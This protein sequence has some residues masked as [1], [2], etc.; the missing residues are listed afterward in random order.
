MCI[1]SFLAKNDRSQQLMK[2]TAHR[3]LS[4]GKAIWI[5][6]KKKKNGERSYLTSALTVIFPLS[7]VQ[8][9]LSSDRKWKKHFM[10]KPIRS[11]Y[12][13]HNWF[14]THS[15]LDFPLRYHR[16][17]R[18][19]SKSTFQLQIKCGARHCPAIIVDSSQM[20]HITV[21][22]CARSESHTHICWYVHA[23]RF[24]EV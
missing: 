4:L 10:A 20:M 8:L 1:F 23:Q 18:H 12:P 3:A 21:F 2:S 13:M 6:G 16:W 5:E 14:S 19:T 17:N 24:G 11:I 22:L 7:F 9:R 15:I